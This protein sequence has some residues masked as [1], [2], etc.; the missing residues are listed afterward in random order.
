MTKIAGEAVKDA[1]FPEKSTNLYSTV[2]LMARKMWRAGLIVFLIG[3]VEVKVLFKLGLRLS[4]C[5]D[6]SCS[7]IF[8]NIHEVVL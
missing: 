3:F 6:I 5:L 2:R 1:G 7:Y 8:F 4:S